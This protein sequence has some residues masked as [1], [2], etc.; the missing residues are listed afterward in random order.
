M[1]VRPGEPRGAAAA[2][3]PVLCL[4]PRGG[5]PELPHPLPSTYTGDPQDTSPCP[6]RTPRGELPEALLHFILLF[7]AALTHRAPAELGPG[8]IVP[9]ALGLDWL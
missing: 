7:S 2:L 9:T 8:W 6:A 4:H 1:H 3:H 5:S